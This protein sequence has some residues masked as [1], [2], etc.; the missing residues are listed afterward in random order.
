MGGLC[1]GPG[2]PPRPPPLHAGPLPRGPLPCA[3][4]LHLGVPTAPAEN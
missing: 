3:G 2:P 4:L 1:A